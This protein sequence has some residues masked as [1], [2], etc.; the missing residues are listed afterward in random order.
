MFP[1]RMR[2]MHDQRHTPPSE[3]PHS[4]L[5]A[6]P[7]RRRCR[8]CLSLLPGATSRLKPAVQ[9]YQVSLLLPKQSCG[10]VT[11]CCKVPACSLSD[12]MLQPRP[13][14]W[15][16]THGNRQRVCVAGC[17]AC[18][19]RA[20]QTRTLASYQP[21]YEVY[22]LTPAPGVTAACSHMKVR[23]QHSKA[24]LLSQ[25][26][27]VMATTWAPMHAPG[28]AWRHCC[29]APSCTPAALSCGSR[30]PN[31]HRKNIL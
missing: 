31:S 10:A 18:E 7:A 27:E 11:L 3:E 1:H 6:I 4:T 29:L 5:S 26:Q 13:R 12:T 17:K 20:S 2:S 19:E 8:C 30:R 15:A 22:T 23:V 21:A 25:V 9:R 28:R 24:H 16:I 14:C